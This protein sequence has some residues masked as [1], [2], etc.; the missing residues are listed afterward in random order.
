MLKK[1]I[2]KISS[3]IELNRKVNI[4]LLKSEYDR[5]V[6][7]LKTKD[8]RIVASYGFKV[9]SQFD[10]DGIIEEIFKR[11]GTTNKIFVEFGVGDGTENNTIYLLLKGWSGLWIEGSKNF[12]DKISLRFAKFIDQKKLI[13]VN[14]FITMDNIDNIISEKIQYEE[15]D[16]LSVDIDGND[17]HILS[18]IKSIKPRVIVLEYNAKF[19]PSLVYCM[20]YKQD[21]VWRKSDNFGASLK[22]FEIQLDELGYYCIGCNIAGTNSFF[23]QKSLV[24]DD[25]FFPPFTSENH[26][27]YARYEMIGIPFG[28]PSI[29]ST[30]DNFN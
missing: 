24:T 29:D 6:D 11:I 5:L 23:V 13:V 7:K 17:S 20:N 1:I 21:Y 15:I 9:F 30:I 2:S 26:F 14:N 25:L 12:V 3:L 16:L 28:H 22:H 18:K 27:Q 10:E 4:S 19:G 8:S